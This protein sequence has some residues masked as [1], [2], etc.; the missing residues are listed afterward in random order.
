MVRRAPARRSSAVRSL[1]EETVKHYLETI[2]YVGHE[3]DRVRPSRIA[4][5]MAVSPATVSTTLSGLEAAGWVRLAADRS[6]SLTTKGR[7]LAEEIVRAHRLV[8]RW[9]TDRLG[10]DWAR[11]DQEAQQLAPAISPTLADRLDDHLGHPATCPHGNVVPGREAPYGTL[12]S[13]ADL[14][15][16]VPARVRRISEVAEH[17]APDL[18]R[19]LHDSGV[20]LGT[21]VVVTGDPAASGAVSIRVGRRALA[22]GTDVARAI[23]VEP[24][25]AR[26][27]PSRGESDDRAEALARGDDRAPRAPGARGHRV[28]GAA[29]RSRMGRDR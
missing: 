10:L 11:A 25:R 6:V 24:A 8:E 19:L 28:R 21:S 23:W 13:L 5:W 22:F 29:D 27:R 26:A 3:E 18:L 20:E 17:D 16:N 15:P 1:R 14:E 2:F 9:L 4:E 7:R 12:I